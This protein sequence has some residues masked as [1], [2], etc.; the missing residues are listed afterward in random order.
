MTLS[1][2]ASRTRWRRAAASGCRRPRSR[3]RPPGLAAGDTAVILHC[4]RLPFRRDGGIYTL[5]LLVAAGATCPTARDRLP[6]FP[7][8]NGSVARG[9][10]GVAIDEGR[11]GGVAHQPPQQRAYRG[12]KVPYYMRSLIYS[13]RANLHINKSTWR[14]NQTIRESSSSAVYVYTVLA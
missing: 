13:P 4:R 12:R 7:K 11:L 3:A 14:R 6:A 10:P 8:K 5:V 9:W 2:T 1:P